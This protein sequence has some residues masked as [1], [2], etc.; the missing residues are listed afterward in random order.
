MNLKIRPLLI[1]TAIGFTV[2]V[3]LI[4]ITDIPI[5]ATASPETPVNPATMAIS[6][7]ASLL[8]L[9]STLVVGMIYPFL[10]GRQEVPLTMLLGILGGAIAVLG[11]SV[12]GTI[13]LQ[14][15]RWLIIPQIVTSI[16]PALSF[17]IVKQILGMSLM[18]GI[19]LF[20]IFVA[21][22]LF[23]SIIGAGGGAIGTFLITRK[24][25]ISSSQG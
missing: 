8:S 24:R 17:E 11:A 21:G 4:L 10:A 7:F 13:F 25:H 19:S 2:Q 18:S 22:W 6:C 14:A 5:I 15:F 3:V 1:A 20:F 9:A 12:L 16:N 23:N